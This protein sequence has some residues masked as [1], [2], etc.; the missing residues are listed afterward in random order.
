MVHVKAPGVGRDTRKESVSS[1]A[2]NVVIG[3][4]KTRGE[5]NARQWVV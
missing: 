4:M 1:F 3:V 5:P 2:S